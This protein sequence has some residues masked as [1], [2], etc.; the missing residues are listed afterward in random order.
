MH[1]RHSEFCVPRGLLHSRHS[2]FHIPLGF[3]I[4]FILCPSRP[5]HTV[6]SE[7]HVS[8]DFCIPFA[9]NSVPLEALSTLHSKVQAPATCWAPDSIQEG[10]RGAYQTAWPLCSLLTLP[11]HPETPAQLSSVMHSLAINPTRNTSRVV[12]ILSFPALLNAQLAHSKPTPRAFHSKC[13][14]L[15]PRK[16]TEARGDFLS[17]VKASFP[18]RTQKVDTQLRKPSPTT[19]KTESLP[20]KTQKDSSWGPPSAI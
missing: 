9:Q 11:Y 12:G 13:S 10:V 20:V 16:E 3:C 17:E 18:L 4:P 7:F 1:A 19:V 15:Q 2:E 6:P 5:L 8:Q 14:V